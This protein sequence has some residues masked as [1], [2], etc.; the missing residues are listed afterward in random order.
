[1]RTYFSRLSPGFRITTSRSMPLPWGHGSGCG[2]AEEKDL[3]R[4]RD[5]RN[6]THNFVHRRFIDSHD[7]LPNKRRI[8]KQGK[9]SRSFVSP[10]YKTAE[11]TAA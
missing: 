11:K 7:L 3:V 5:S 4:M 1:M 8:K 6:A 10:L 9:R 2:G